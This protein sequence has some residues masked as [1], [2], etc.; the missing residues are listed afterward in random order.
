MNKG[1]V[2]FLMNQYSE[3]DLHKRLE[4]AVAYQL[5]PLKLKVST[6]ME[7]SKSLLLS[8]TFLLYEIVQK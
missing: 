5:Y 4:E 3:N 1:N 6:K 8:M 2:G 7:K